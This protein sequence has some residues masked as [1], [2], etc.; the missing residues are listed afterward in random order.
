MMGGGLATASISTLTG[1][2]AAGE[3]RRAAPKRRW[4]RGRGG[5]EAADS[6]RRLG[7]HQ[8]RPALRRRR[9]RRQSFNDAAAAGL[10][11]AKAE[12]GIE[13]EESTRRATAT[14]PSAERSLARRLRPDDRGRLPWGD[15]L[16]EVAAAAPDTTSASSTRS[17]TARTSQPGL[18]RG[19]GLV[20]GRCRRRAEDQDRPHRLHRWRARQRPH[21]EV[22]GRLRRRR[23]GASIPTSRSTCKYLTE[24]PDF[25]GFQRPGPRQ[26][27][28]PR[29]CTTAAPTSC[30]RCRRVRF[31]RARGDVGGGRPRQ[32][33]GHRRRLRPV[34]AAPSPTVQA[35]HPHVDAQARRRRRVRDHPL[36]GRRRHF[37]GWRQRS[38]TCRTTASAT[39][40]RVASST[41]SRTKLDGSR[42]TSS[43]TA[44][45]VGS[46]R[47]PDQLNVH[48]RARRPVRFSEGY[49]SPEARA[50]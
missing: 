27:R 34:P 19:A 17:S 24:A 31:G 41:T 2:A 43:S 48:A 28:S 29:R 32:R 9:P 33:L 4:R 15:A 40:P 45:I 1:G 16:A 12:L 35:V 44:K 21:Q 22:R 38:S 47:R 8:R 25:I 42:P 20:P 11:E 50:T 18:R 37:A 26:G 46:D 13:A 10:D 36:R 3:A 7:R 23:Q 49:R 6:R 39:R 5:T 14:G 30:T